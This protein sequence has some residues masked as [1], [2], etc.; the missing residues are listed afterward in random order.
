MGRW[1]FYVPTI[2]QAMRG[3]EVLRASGISAFIGRNTDMNAGA[4]CSY[5]ISVTAGGAAAER[6]LRQ[7][8]IKITRKDTG[9]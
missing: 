9:R 8:R 6:I 1:N 5:S 3:K 7:H 4:G 2:T